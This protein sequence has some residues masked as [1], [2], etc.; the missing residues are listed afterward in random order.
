MGQQQLLLIVLGVIVV[1]VAVV[2]G[3]GLFTANAEEAVKDELVNQCV[4]IGAHAQQY[5]KKPLAMG[6]GG[7]A[8]TNYAIPN[9]MSATTNCGGIGADGLPVAAGY[10]LGAG[11]QTVTITATP[12]DADYN[13]TV[14]ATVTK[15]NITTVVQ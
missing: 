5:Y 1:A 10:V 9:R 4:A 13:W 6:G 7:L 15:D 11:D 3:I 12:L 2:A 14:V 8:F